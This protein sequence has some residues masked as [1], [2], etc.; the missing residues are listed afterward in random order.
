MKSELICPNCSKK[1]DLY[2]NEDM[3]FISCPNLH[4]DYES[5]IDMA[6]ISE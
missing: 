5:T 2:T 3:I 6:F 1:L 4:C